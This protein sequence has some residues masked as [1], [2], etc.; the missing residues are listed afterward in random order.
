MGQN[1]GFVLVYLVFILLVPVITILLKI[2]P[3]DKQNR[4]L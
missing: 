1:M 2:F 4:L 3:V